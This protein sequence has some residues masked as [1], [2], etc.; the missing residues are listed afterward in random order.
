MCLIRFRHRLVCIIDYCRIVLLKTYM[1]GD[2]RQEFLLCPSTSHLELFDPTNLSIL[3]P[4][5]P[6]LS[7]V[8]SLD[9]TPEP[10]GVQCG[11]LSTCIARAA[12]FIF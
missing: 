2:G 4:I 7:D 11:T 10:S 6:L 3:N 9:C 5:P 8:I 12:H 1:R